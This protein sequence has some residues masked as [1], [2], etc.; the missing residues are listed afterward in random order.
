M[1]AGF[2]RSRHF[3][4]QTPNIVAAL[5]IREASRKENENHG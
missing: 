4:H 2:R 1:I 5:V 3:F